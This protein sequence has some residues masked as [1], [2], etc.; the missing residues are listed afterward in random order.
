M[1]YLLLLASIVVL[2]TL[3]TVGQLNVAKNKQEDKVTNLIASLPYLGRFDVGGVPGRFEPGAGEIDFLY[4]RSIL[5]EHQ[6]DG[7]I[8]FETIPSDGEFAT[9]VNAIDR[10]FPSSWCGERMRAKG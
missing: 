8:T 2:S 4:L 10:I 9:A 1:K 3:K 7:T 5:D 6:W